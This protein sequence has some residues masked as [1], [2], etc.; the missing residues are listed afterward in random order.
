MENY[1]PPSED[2]GWIEIIN[3]L[4]AFAEDQISIYTWFRGDNALL[5]GFTADDFTRE[6]IVRYL[7]DPSIYNPGRGKFFA[8]LKYYFLECFWSTSSLVTS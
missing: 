6:T 5:Q 4:R 1:A 8:F 2:Q 3:R 7:E